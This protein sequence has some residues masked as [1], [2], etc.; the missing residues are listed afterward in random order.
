M[1]QQVIEQ[2]FV[3]IKKLKPGEPIAS[4]IEIKKDTTKQEKLGSPKLQEWMKKHARK[5][6]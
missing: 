2:F 6:R 5:G 3:P 4:P 1:T